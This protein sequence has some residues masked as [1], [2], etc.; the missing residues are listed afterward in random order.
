MTVADRG[1]S[2]LGR[3]TTVH[4][5]NSAGT[6]FQA[7]VVNGKFDGEIAAT[8]PSGSCTRTDNFTFCP[9]TSSVSGSSLCSHSGRRRA[10]PTCSRAPASPIPTCAA[11]PNISVD[12]ASATTV[13]RIDSSRAASAAA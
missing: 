5:V 7:L 13:A 10:I 4:P 1:V 12:P 11:R 3:S 8:T 6:T 9:A 2:G